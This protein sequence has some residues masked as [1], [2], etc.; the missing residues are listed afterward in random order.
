MNEADRDAALL[1]YVQQS[2]ARIEE[3][4][5]GGRDALLTE[6]IVQDAVLRR[7]ETLADA[8]S[9][10]SEPIKARHPDIRWRAIQGF[11]NVAA[12]AYLELDLERVWTTIQAHL[13]ALKAVVEQEIERIS[14]G[15]PTESDSAGR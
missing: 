6:S 3:Y 7:L 14:T 13:P 12:H 15:P 10:L 8:A 2:V 4:T 11:R 9:R 1:R 5:R